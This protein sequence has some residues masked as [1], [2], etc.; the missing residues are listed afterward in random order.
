M[1]TNSEIMNKNDCIYDD[2]D[3]HF[4]INIPYVPPILKGQ[5][6]GI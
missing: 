2:H 4:A 1:A 5:E 3:R 6:M